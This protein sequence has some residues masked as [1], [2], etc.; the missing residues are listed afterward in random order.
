MSVCVSASLIHSQAQ[1]SVHKYPP[2][3]VADCCACT[4]MDLQFQR[5]SI[6]T[7]PAQLPVQMTNSSSIEPWMTPNQ[8]PAKQEVSSISSLVPPTVLTLI[9]SYEATTPVKP[10]S[11][12]PSSSAVTEE[13][14]PPPTPTSGSEPSETHDQNCQSPPLPC[15]AL[16]EVQPSDGHMLEQTSVD[17]ILPKDSSEEETGIVIF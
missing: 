15:S 7:P 10:N 17:L 5:K 14:Q 8:I 3:S 11:K 6:G 4:S 1:V 9:P 13:A 16:A 12:C 2:Q